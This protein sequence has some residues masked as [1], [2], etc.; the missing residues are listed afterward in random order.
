[1]N[2]KKIIP[3]LLGPL[4]FFFLQSLNTPEGMSEAAYAVLCATLWIAIWWVSEAVPIAVT[5]LL[6]IVLFP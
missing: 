3:L 2:S 6:P 1:M 4:L 5:S